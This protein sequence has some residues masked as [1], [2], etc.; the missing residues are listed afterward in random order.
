MS[1]SIKS[2]GVLFL[3]FAFVLIV[4]TAVKINTRG[5]Y[6]TCPEGSSS[7]YISD[8]PMGWRCVLGE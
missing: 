5:E 3:V 2:I 1:D 7:V 8:P 6:V 4:M